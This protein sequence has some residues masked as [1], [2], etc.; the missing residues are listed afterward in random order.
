M[1]VSK[2]LGVILR[3]HWAAAVGSV[4]LLALGACSLLLDRNATECTTNADCLQFGVQPSCV[5][6]ACVNTKLPC[7]IGTPSGAADFL[8]QCSV[9]MCGA[10]DDCT[11]LGLCGDAAPPDAIVPPDQ[12]AAPATLTDAGVMPSCA[13]LTSGAANGVVYATGSSNFPT[14]LESVVPY[15]SAPQGTPPH[16]QGPEVIYQTTNSCTGAARIFTDA[17]MMYDPPAGGTQ[18][19]EYYEADADGG[20]VAVP[21]LL[22]PEG[23]SVDV[24]ESDVYSTT[25]NFPV[26]NGDSSYTDS[27]GPAQ[28]MAFVVNA[29]STQTSISQAAAFEVFGLGGNDGGASPW[30]DPSLYYIRNK[31]TGTQQM[32]GQE[33]HVPADQFWG[34]DQ[35]SAKNLHDRLESLPPQDANAAIGIISVDVYD[36]DRDNLK[37]LAY[38]AAGQECAYLPDSTSTTYDKQ[39]L[40]DGH[41]PIWGPLHFFTN[42]SNSNMAASTFV[43]YFA[44]LTVDETLLGAII[45]ASLVP[46]C[47]MSVQR[48]PSQYAELSPLVSYTPLHSCTCYFLAQANLLAQTPSPLPS[49]CSACMTASDCPPS[50]PSCNYN[51][52]EVQ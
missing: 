3:G 14:L 15:I 45:S 48:S 34:V 29:A 4:A 18:Y 28:G 44:A 10:F 47:A 7:F 2:S 1:R 46:S 42:N 12:A 17:G 40:R 35:G 32:I 16:A 25:C 20:S 11:R 8:N 6:G 19:A 50:R 51:F 52:C 24:G 38:Q 41:Y 23:H 49:E 43:D 5:N 39:N 26:P 22:G 37:V 36:S 27:L 33:I 9:A 13:E 30:L 21:C 31:N